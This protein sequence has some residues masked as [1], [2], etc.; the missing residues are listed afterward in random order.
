MIRANG[1]PKPAYTPSGKTGLFSFSLLRHLPNPVLVINPDT[2]ILYVNLELEQLVGFSFAELAGRRAPYPWWT[3][4]TPHRTARDFAETIRAGTRKAEELIASRRGERF[5]VE[6]TTTPV[7]VGGGTSFFLSSWVDI[8]ARKRMQEALLESEERSQRLSDVA[9]EGIA[10][11]EDFRIQDANRAYAA[12]HG[13]ELSEMIGMPALEL[14]AP[15][16]RETGI[17]NVASGFDKL[18]EQ[19]HLR[20]D[21]SRF[22]VEVIGK[23]IQYKGRHV[24]V[25]AVRDITERLR[26]E[27]RLRESEEKLRVMFES[28]VEGIIVCDTSGRINQVNNAALDMHGFP[29]RDELIGQNILKLIARQ[30]HNRAIKD[31]DWTLEKERVHS[32]EYTCLRKNGTEFAAELSIALLGPSASPAGIVVVARDITERKRQTERMLLYISQITRAQEEERKRVARELHD[33]TI[34]SLVSLS[35]EIESV[36]RRAEREQVP[37]KDDLA[38]LLDKTHVIIREVRRF[39]HELRPD[40]LDRLGLVPA[41][42]VLS[43]ETFRDSAINTS[44]TT[45][46]TERR[47]LPEIELAL[48]RITQEALRNARRHSRATEIQIKVEF[49]AAK[50]RLVVTDNGKGF[51]LPEVQSRLLGERK[52]GLIGMQER[53]LLV[54]GCFAIQSGVNSGTA[55]SV[56]IADSAPEDLS[57]LV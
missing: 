22:N 32:A 3:E 52:M 56:E 27:D 47:L 2:S 28:L 26:M 12:M 11:V 15:E 14:V 29:S 4:A 33:E 6:M 50:V 54:G 1:R 17:K 40:I 38:G 8:T 23:N 43:E 41:L 18:Y 13:Y 57:P 37:V 44:L 16:Y 42:E 25:A 51:Q 31:R 21:G 49:A 9:F 36:R 19:V 20:K 5:W 53:A 46:E 30:D 48:F 45:S 24:R 39:S 10:I 35:L 55:I 7:V 34:Q